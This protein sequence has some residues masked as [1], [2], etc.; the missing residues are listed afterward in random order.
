MPLEKDSQ[1][2][3][4][5]IMP[6]A[7]G[8]R[9]YASACYSARSHIMQLQLSSWKLPGTPLKKHASTYP[10]SSRRDAKVHMIGDRINQQLLR[11]RL[12]EQLMQKKFEFDSL[13]LEHNLRS[14]HTLLALFQPLAYQHLRPQTPTRQPGSFLPDSFSLGHAT[15][16]VRPQSLRSV[17]M[18][19]LP[20]RHGSWYR[21]TPT[22]FV[23]VRRQLA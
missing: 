5:M 10:R 21:I 14:F 7:K 11:L 3:A 23:D 19:R 8:K 13:I 12:S 16:I 17:R 2:G 4:S 15:C 9:W 6:R 18:H 22:Q 20:I 1:R